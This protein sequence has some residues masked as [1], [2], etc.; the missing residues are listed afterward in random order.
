MLFY[1]HGFKQNE[2]A[3]IMQIQRAAVGVLLF[4]ARSRLAELLAA[5]FGKQQ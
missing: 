5:I 3:T 1:Y 4:Q 2:I